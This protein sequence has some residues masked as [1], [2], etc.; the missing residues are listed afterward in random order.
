L[1]LKNWR[2]DD[3]NKTPQKSQ[4]EFVKFRTWDTHT[5]IA[6]II[7]GSAASAFE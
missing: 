6:G 5:S 3:F 7:N 1:E 4:A 2:F